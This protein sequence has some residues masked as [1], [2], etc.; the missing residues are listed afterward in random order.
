[1][2]SI[3]N[4][5]ASGVLLSGIVALVFATSGWPLA[6]FGT[7]CAGWWRWRRWLSSWS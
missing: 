3:Y 2:L 1:M 7:R 5:M 4:Y 6:V